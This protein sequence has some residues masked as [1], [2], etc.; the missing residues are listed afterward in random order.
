MNYK[1]NKKV[2]MQ[3]QKDTYIFF[4]M[5]GKGYY[6]IYFIKFF[7]L[8]LLKQFNLQFNNMWVFIFN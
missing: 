3:K 4:F 5:T 7:I 1:A 2:F 8:Y 6:I